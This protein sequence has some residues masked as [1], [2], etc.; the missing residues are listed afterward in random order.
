MARDLLQ[1]RESIYLD[2]ESP[3]DLG[4]LQDAEA[5]LSMHLGKL[6]ILDEVQRKPKIFQVLRV[7]IDKGRQLG[8][9]HAQYLILGSASLDLLQ[10]SSE[11]LAGRIHYLELTGFNA[12]EVDDLNK[13]WVGGGFP[14]SYTARNE[15]ISVQWR[16]DLV[17]TFLERDVPSFGFRIPTTTLRRMWTMLAYTQGTM[18]NYSKLAQGLEISSVSVHRYIDLLCDLLLV[19]KIQPYLNNGRKR[20]VKVPKVYIRDSGL[21]HQ[22]LNLNSIE[23]VLSN[24]VVGNSW[25]GF[26]IENILGTLPNYVKYSYYRTGAGAEIDL[27][28]EVGNAEIWAIEIKQS[29]NP[30]VTKGFHSACEDLAPTR[31]YVIYNGTET[32]P[33]PEHV[34]AIGLKSML[35]LLSEFFI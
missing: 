35:Q 3:Q 28:L 26:V 8:I 5:Y 19:R 15:K 20:L 16:E 23:G 12:L 9:S 10:Q 29:S 33:L 31:K 18:S 22:L 6:V 21:V 25:E 11:T 7:L 4:K 32:Y 17:K 34:M 30:R 27:V 13:L 14:D 24:P 2:L 1:N